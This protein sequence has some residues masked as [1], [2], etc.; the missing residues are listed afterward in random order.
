MPDYQTI[1]NGHAE[2]YENLV[3]REDCQGNLA[4]VLKVFECEPKDLIIEFGAGTGRL[5]RIIAPLAEAALAFDA[6]VSMLTVA[7]RE[8]RKRK[9]MNVAFGAALNDRMP[10][11][12]SCAALTLAGWTFGHLPGWHPDDWPRRI[13]RVVSE[14]L[15]V[16][17]PGGT[18]VIIETLGTGRDTPRPPTDAL[19]RYYGILEGEFGFGRKTVRTDYRFESLDEAERL[20][21]FFFGDDL[22]DRVRREELIQLPECTGI[23]TLTVVSDA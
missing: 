4:R 22:A 3:S 12:D 8:L 21:R 17:V 18:A 13:R 7:R 19:A 14:M 2:E 11:R 20:T 5:T 16:T 10:V 1:Y 23:W 15:R 9:A 6:S